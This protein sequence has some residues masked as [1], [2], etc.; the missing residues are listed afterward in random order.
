MGILLRELMAFY[1][2]FISGEPANLPSLPLQYADFAVWQREWLQGEELKKHLAW[3]K[4]ALSGAP[5]VLELPSDRPRP[6][7]QS[8]RGRCRSLVLPEPLTKAIRA[9]GRQEG[10]TLFITLFAAFQVLLSRLTGRKDILVGSPVA[11]RRHSETESLIGLFINTLVLRGDLSGNPSFKDLLQRTKETSLEAWAHQDLPL[12]KLVEELRPD[13]SSSATPLIQA[14]FALQQTP[15]M[16]STLPGLTVEPI[17][18]EVDTATAKFDLTFHVQEVGS[19]LKAIAEYSTDLFDESS[20]DRLMQRYQVLL[21]AIVADP[22]RPVGQQPLLT[23]AER[24]QI[25]VDWNRTESDY[26]KNA[27]VPQLFEEQVARTPDATAVIF[28]N[29]RL[30]YRVLNARAN[31]VAEELRSRQVDP[32]AF[33]AVCLNRSGEAIS[34]LLG[35]LKAGAAYVA[36]D[37]DMPRARLAEVL[38]D[39][40]AS[41][42]LTSQSILQS[43]QLEQLGPVGEDKLQILCVDSLKGESRPDGEPA[44][45]NP[46][47]L[48]YVSFTSGST[49]RPKGVCVPHRAVVRLVKGADYATFH[50]NDVFLQLAPLSF[51]ASTFEIWGALLNGATLAVFPPHTPSLGELGQFIRQHGITTLW[52]TSGLFHQM[53]DEQIENLR[54]VRQLLAG[55]DVLSVAHVQKALQHLPACRLI[56]GYGPTENTTFT[57][58]HRVPAALG[59]VRSV[60]IGRP[61]ANTRVYVLDEELQPVPVGVSGE[62]YAA[63]D[64]LAAGYLNQPE[65]TAKK[66][67]NHS[68]GQRRERLYKTGDCVRWLPD[69]ALEFLGRADAQVK[70]HGFRVEPAEIE[71]VLAAHENVKQCAVTSHQDGRGEKR[72]VAYLVLQPGI[73][74]ESAEWRRL[75]QER[76][77]HY[78]VPS[79]FVFLDDLPLQANGKVERSALVPPAPTRSEGKEQFVAPR[80]PV[81]TQMSALWEEIL[82]VRPISVLDNFFELGGHS[83]LAVRLLAQVER[84]FG[85][86]LPVATVFQWPVLEQFVQRLRQEKSGAPRKSASILEIQPNGTR[87]P[88]FLVHGAGGGM[89]WGYANLAVHLGSDQ[90]VYAFKC[91][92]LEGNGEPEPATVREMAALYLSEMRRLQ[93]CGPYY[94]GG[95]CFGGNVA[96]EIACQLEAQGEIVALLVLLNSA[97]THSNRPAF[98]HGFR[99]WLQFFQNAT[100][101][102]ISFFSH[103]LVEQRKFL[104][105]WTR[106]L[107]RRLFPWLGESRH[108][109]DLCSETFVDLSTSSPEQRRLWKTHYRALVGHRDKPYAGR[110][111][112][113]RSRDFPLWCAFDPTYG[114]SEFVSGDLAVQI[115][116]GA[117]EQ[118]LQEPHV[119]I[120]A[121][122]FARSLRQTQRHQLG[123]AEI[124]S[125]AASDVPPVDAAQGLPLSFV[126]ESLW[127]SG[128]NEPAGPLHHVPIAIR[129]DGHLDVRTLRRALEEIVRRHPPLRTIF[130]EHEGGAVQKI[131]TEHAVSFCRVD[132]S[133]KTW[134]EAG[135]NLAVQEA[136]RPFTPRHQPLL[137]ATLFRF[138]DHQHVLLL[139]SHELILD[140]H[141][142]RLLRDELGLC[143]ESLAEGRPLTWPDLPIDYADFA[144][145]Q[146]KASQEPSR[147]ADLDYWKQQLAGMPAL[148]EWPS[149]HIRPPVL[150]HR[151]GRLPIT[152]DLALTNAL[153]MLGDGQRT[154][155]SV[156]LVAAI[157]AFAHRYTGGDDIVIGV[158]ST[159]RTHDTESVLGNFGQTLIART[160][161]SGDPTFCELLGRASE[162]FNR[163]NEHR[164]VPV[165]V[166]VK[167]LAP[168]DAG[169][170]AHPLFQLAF[171]L[172]PSEA[173]PVAG[174]AVRWTG[175]D[176]DIGLTPFDLRFV[177][178]EGPNG[179]AGWL[180][181]N[182]DLFEPPTMER[183]LGHWMTLLKEITTFP[184]RRLSEIQLLSAGEEKELLAQQRGPSTTFPSEFCV[185]QLFERQVAECPEERAV[186]FEGQSLS[187]TALNGRASQLAQRLQA[188]GVGPNVPVGIALERSLEVPVAV[189]AI[190]KA[191]GAYVPLDPAY[192]RERLRLMIENARISVLLSTSQLRSSLGLSLPNLQ[193]V[194]LDDEKPANETVQAGPRKPKPE[195]YHLAYVIH[196]SGSTGVPKGVAM[197]HRP[198]VNLITWQAKSSSAKRGRRTLQFAS[199]S[200]DV[201]FQEMF[202]T[203]S[204]GGTL[205]LM[206]EALRRDPV[207]LLRLIVEKR[208]ER[209]YLPFVALQHLAEAFAEQSAP[210]ISLREVITAGEQLQ[211]TPGIIHLFAHLPGCVL[212]N[213]YG[214]TESHVVTAFD[215]TG[216]PEQ[217]PALPPIGRPI[218]NV[219]IHVLD[220]RGRPVPVGVPG[221]LFIGGEALASGYLHK[222][223][224]TAERF[225]PNRLPGSEPN[226]RLYRTGDLARYR[227]DGLI[228]FLGR[229]DHQVKIRG[230]RVELGEVEATLQKH[231]GVRDVVVTAHQ[232]GAGPKRLAA[233]CVMKDGERLASDEFRRWLGAR[234]PEYMVPSFLVPLDKLPLTPNGKVDRKRL[235][236]PDG[237][238]PEL[239][240]RFEA[241]ANPVEEKLAR[242]WGEVLGIH[243][244][245]ARDNFFD[246]GGHSLL[247]MQIMSR[248]RRDFG[249][250]LP[251]ACLF[252]TP[253]PAGLAERI[254]ASDVQAPAP[255]LKAEVRDGKAALSFSQQRLWLIHQFDPNSSAYHV[256]VAVLLEGNVDSAVLENSLRGIVERHEIL[257]TRF[258]TVNGEPTQEILPTVP[259]TL[260][261]IDWS[262]RVEV[263]DP[264]RLRSLLN[265]EAREPFDLARPPLFRSTLVRLPQSRHVLLVV[266]HHIISDGWSLEIFFRELAVL[267]E[268]RLAGR[269][270]ALPALPI[271]YADYADWQRQSMSS[272]VLDRHLDYFRETLK[273]ARPSVALPADGPTQSGQAGLG[274][275]CA[276]TLSR[277]LLKS[278]GELQRNEGATT[279]MSLLAGLT[280]LIYRWTGQKDMVLGTVAAGRDRPEV[281]PLIGCFMNFLPLRLVLKEGE[282]ALAVLRQ[283]KA[284]VLGSYSHGGCPFEKIVEA[285]NP[286]RSRDGYPLYNVAVLLQNFPGMVLST[287]HL[288][289]HP[290]PVD[291]GAALLD[292][293]FVAEEAGGRLSVTC[294]YR[295]DRFQSTTIEWLLLGLNQCL[296]ALAGRPETRVED[297]ALTPPEPKREPPKPQLPAEED[298]IAVAATFTAEPVQD[299]LQFWLRELGRAARLEFAPYNQ[300]FQQLLDPASLLGRNIHGLNVVLIRMED[301]HRSDEESNNDDGTVAPERIE[302]TARE[303]SAALRTA[304]GRGGEF[305]VVICPSW[306]AVQ[307]RPNLEGFFRRQEETLVNDLAALP[308]VRIVTS[309]E[310]LEIYD[311]CELADPQG[312]RLGHVPY[313]A[314]FFAALGTMIARKADAWKRPRPKVV[315]LDCDQTLWAGVCAEDTPQG[316]KLDAPRRALQEF[317]R[318]RM[319]EGTLLGLCSKNQESDVEAVFSAHPEMP[320]RR[321][322][323]A[324]VR[325]NW[326]AKSENL[327][328]IARELGLGLD[329]FV[330]MDDSPIEC[331]EVEANTPEVL[332]L[333]IPQNVEKLPAFLKHCWIFDC[334]K[335]TSEDKQRTVLYQENRAREEL[336]AGATSL[337]E[338]IEQLGL[339]VRIE[340]LAPDQLTRT[341]QLTQKTNQ[342]N[343]TTRRRTENDILELQRLGQA[344]ILVASVKDKFGDYGLGRSDHFQNHFGCS[345]RRHPLAELSRPGTRG[346]TPNGGS[347]RTNRSPAGTA[348]GGPA[349]S[350]F[351]QKPAR[352]RLCGKSRRIP[353]TR[354]RRRNA[355]PARCGYRF[356]GCICTKRRPACPVRRTSAG[357]CHGTASGLKPAKIYAL[358]VDCTG[359]I[360]AIKVA[361]I[362]RQKWRRPCP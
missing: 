22:G 140:A 58:C 338:F 27:T 81:E 254:S 272:L 190:L 215:L 86:S 228:E 201:S 124:P 319:A 129:L 251:L 307:K 113:L 305:L 206:K 210:P 56:N 334:W 176:L 231:P 324:S 241:P 111:T 250:D 16:M 47:N 247:A 59:D 145:W 160:E 357:R 246:L 286:E 123:T 268:A 38:R 262:E 280:I 157:Q 168:D 238:R 341:A 76:L 6:S 73:A 164:Q 232:N 19:T 71:A 352:P 187:Y 49:G 10:V 289:G 122:H 316:V 42:L 137:R 236:A 298:L 151:G 213:H 120:L 290:I 85:K 199:L 339:E 207:A 296:E 115:V 127:R 194:C 330:F 83:L 131:L 331:A 105:W 309:R 278:L 37:P 78:M 41:I 77:P 87:P 291:T 180:E 99:W 104:A 349:V 103:P 249:V 271:Q 192:P 156:T 162:T 158:G 36:L 88:L 269:P 304:A 302:A 25:L 315:V 161:L 107:A 239:E 277:S 203:W 62:L 317:M 114:W 221:E 173:I 362:D 116:P 60:P 308:R 197:P 2:E 40:S 353:A 117:H 70:I 65:L 332:V 63:G 227:A 82:G 282:T 281:E 15:L 9:L 360:R 89:L 212:S 240:N 121:S 30:S 283:A 18:E 181:F 200:F 191:G 327:R 350:G 267:Y 133:G 142:Q 259:V 153:R 216:S 340:E 17:S 325:I 348:F 193:W 4:Q 46:D 171:S 66:F 313:T 275:E 148:L 53:V 26:P 169:R 84:T 258:I 136:R 229:M 93:P 154:H 170:S 204:T 74:G 351:F 110:V 29:Q 279:F 261:Q 28:Q 214:P 34:S 31:R 50:P 184:E 311:V 155:L 326:K 346:G 182:R 108:P 225:V 97:P 223:E 329:S 297:I 185:H 119:K 253:T 138:S 55:G 21:E 222:P 335:I 134:N 256:P 209:I 202:G 314:E 195:P 11:G 198:L 177:L 179:L 174:S 13:R 356:P 218:D 45:I 94:L 61:I 98:R 266:M 92:S 5:D 235:P 64:G 354:S 255:T 322:D 150:T 301:W 135:M 126:Q 166:L 7:Q 276:V 288:K 310:L 109:D 178:K 128:Q 344:E 44:E 159:H 100:H 106:T 68:I 211:I 35:I 320:L 270:A 217:W 125:R 328:S 144:Q 186:E 244:V 359:N 75:L 285:L 263:E 318:S 293:R 12:E 333:Q 96:Y 243:K 20:I 292:L 245:G 205:V 226:G 242:I 139:V 220:P 312:D 260:A 287:P 33:V 265:A 14:M 264:S 358:R 196:T 172:E 69:G 101:S 321:Q 1:H 57:C 130:P 257:R 3:W 306:K 54:G 39:A 132:L 79:Q 230:F 112:L 165:E 163:A 248:V 152:I 141:S 345:Q 95:Y 118:I 175:V 274:P 143:Y 295:S 208:I 342:F 224:L 252:E 23:G 102:L 343:L 323:F 337:R 147:R 233:Y 273:G 237:E 300:V 336:R 48:A 303:L 8:F 52:L 284:A 189:L 91:K 80:D 51:D 347:S 188:L 294:E 32:G 167:E 43:R 361:P 149:D 183:W 24:Q 72:L 67:L 146:R 355:L 90:P 234:L 219:Q 299:A